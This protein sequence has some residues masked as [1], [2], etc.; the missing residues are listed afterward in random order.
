MAIKDRSAMDQW[1]E[2]VQR[3][4]T[5]GTNIRALCR[6][7]AVAPKTL[8]TKVA[9]YQAEGVAGLLPRSRRPHTSPT[10]TAPVV[11]ARVLALRTAHPTW[12]GRK[13]QAVLAREGCTP[14]PAH[15]TITAILR[16]HGYLDGPRAGKPRAFTRFERDQPNALWQLDFMGHRPMA[17]GRV[18][19]LTIIDDHSRFGLGLFACPHEQGDLVQQHLISVFRRVGLPEAILADNGSLWANSAP[20]AITRL[21]VWW[22]RLGIQ[23]LHGRPN[24]PQ[25]QGKVERW[26]ATI[27]TEVF[28]QQC[29]LTLAAAQTAFD[30]FR[31]CYNTERPHESLDWEVPSARYQPSA[32]RYPETLPEPPAGDAPTT[33]RVN[34]NGYIRYDGRR[35]YVGEALGGLPVGLY[36]TTTDGII[37][38][39]FCD[40]EIKHLDLRHEA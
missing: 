24:H 37:A 26:H 31:H 16:R 19:P 27:A 9:R 25:T 22:M 15:T 33:Q 6:E 12:G 38:V 20:S 30:T 28:A 18:H 5:E 17:G 1:L 13:L 32:C 2:I 21:E 36:P 10:R 29:F 11:E 39:R 40:Q 35:L 4:L 8:Y 7:Y 14:L 23:V 34:A 3:A